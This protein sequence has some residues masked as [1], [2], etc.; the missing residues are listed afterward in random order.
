[1]PLGNETIVPNYPIISARPH[2]G[3]AQFGLRHVYPL[4]SPCKSLERNYISRIRVPSTNQTRLQ[5]SHTCTL[6]PLWTFWSRHLTALSI[7]ITL[8]GGWRRAH[9]ACHLTSIVETSDG[10]RPL[11]QLWHKEEWGEHGR[12]KGWMKE[13]INPSICR[14]VA[15]RQEVNASKKMSSLLI[16]S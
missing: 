16:N 10:A 3:T 15:V 6:L 2:P 14:W 12:T 4:N 1:M 13:E 9:Y 11:N 7:I 5:F 8:P